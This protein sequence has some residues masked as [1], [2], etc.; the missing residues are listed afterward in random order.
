MKKT[1]LMNYWR[2]EMIPVNYFYE[3]R[4]IDEETPRYGTSEWD[5]FPGY[6]FVIKRKGKPKKELDMYWDEHTDHHLFEVNLNDYLVFSHFDGINF[7]VKIEKVIKLSH[8]K[9]LCF[10]EEKERRGFTKLLYIYE[11]GKWNVKPPQFLNS[12]ID[13]ASVIARSLP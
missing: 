12:S 9:P 6:G 10:N 11:N 7:K 8:K 5:C 13:W 3:E 1:G 4:R 2:F